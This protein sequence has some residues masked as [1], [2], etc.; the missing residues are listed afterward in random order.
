MGAYISSWVVWR[1][2]RGYRAW[3]WTEIADSRHWSDTFGGKEQ[4]QRDCGD[5]EGVGKE[6]FVEDHDLPEPDGEKEESVLERFVDEEDGK[7][8][9]AGCG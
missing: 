7:G 3:R 8:E 2:V 9:G 6:T 1:A 5:S 4:P